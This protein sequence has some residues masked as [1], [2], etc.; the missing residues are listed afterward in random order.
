[1]KINCI[2]K[3]DD[4]SNRIEIKL[5]GNKKYS[6]L[7]P[8]KIMASYQMVKAVKFTIKI[9]QTNMFMICI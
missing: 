3:G 6:Q 9:C 4:H 1:M 2:S 7:N 8:L 5:K